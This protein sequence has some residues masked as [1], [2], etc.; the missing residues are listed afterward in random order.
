[1]SIMAS[2]LYNYTKE[3]LQKLLNESNSYADLL[4]KIG[5]SEHGGNRTTLRKIINE[6]DLDLTQISENRRLENLKILDNLHKKPKPLNEILVNNSQYKSSDLLKRLFAEGYKEKKCECCGITEWM[7]KDIA[8]QLHHKDGDNHNNELGN[9]ESLCPNCHSQT[10]NFAG[11]SSSKIPKLTKNQEKKKAQH[12]I[13]EDGQ[14]LY[15]GYGNY[16][17]LCPVCNKNF[18]NKEAEMCRQCYD[19]ERNEPKISKEE[20][21]ELVKNNSFISIAKILNVNKKTVSRWYKHYID[22]EK[23]LGNIVICSDKAPSREEL[24]KNLFKYK[25]FTVLASIYDVTDN[26]VRKWCDAYGLPRHTKTIRS[27]SDEEWE[28]I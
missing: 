14:R 8:F 15:D 25:T 27:I 23:K 5:M 10:D 21:F 12:G 7:D 1:M 9:L 26:T 28:N 22:E 13:S 17:L 2:R 6:Y 20:L 3:E 18:M 16:K 4:R 19:K 11:K 24:K